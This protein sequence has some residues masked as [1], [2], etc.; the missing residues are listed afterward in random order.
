MQ[1]VNIGV[2]RRT[3]FTLVYYSC[4]QE[5]EESRQKAEDAEMA[6]WTRPQDTPTVQQGPTPA[7][8]AGSLSDNSGQLSPCTDLPQ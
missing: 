4:I 8:P 6:G 5:E 7:G 2:S 1:N 3:V